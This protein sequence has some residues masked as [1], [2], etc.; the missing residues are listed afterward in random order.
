MQIILVSGSMESWVGYRILISKYAGY[1]MQYVGEW[2]GGNKHGQG[3]KYDRRGQIEFE[4]IT[5]R[6]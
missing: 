3:V 6:K 4:W 1:W 5:S 2:R